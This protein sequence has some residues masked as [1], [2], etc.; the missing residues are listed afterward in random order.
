MCDFVWERES[1]CENVCASD[2]ETER[3]IEHAI[4]RRWQ[5]GSLLLVHPVPNCGDQRARWGV[6]MQ[7]A[8]YTDAAIAM[9][10]KEKKKERRR[11]ESRVTERKVRDTPWWTALYGASHCKDEHTQV[12]TA[13]F[14]GT[15]HWHALIVDRLTLIHP[16]L[17]P[18]PSPQPG[19][20]FFLY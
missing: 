7:V 18:C 11:K 1:V 5:M 20:P 17:T 15:L 6:C 12:C 8:G 9:G 3:Y 2:R 10:K 14:V 19:A 4:Q 13:I 16:E